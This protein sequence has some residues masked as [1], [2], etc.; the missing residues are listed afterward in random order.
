MRTPRRRPSRPLRKRPRIDDLADEEPESSS[1]STSSESSE[2]SPPD[3]AADADDEEGYISALEEKPTPTPQ[4]RRPSRLAKPRCFLDAVRPY[5]EP[6]SKDAVKLSQLT[7]AEINAGEAYRG[8]LVCTDADRAEVEA[9]RVTAA[10]L[11]GYDS[12]DFVDDTEEVIPQIETRSVSLKRRTRSRNSDH[13]S[14]DSESLSSESSSDRPSEPESD[15][16]PRGSA[17]TIEVRSSHYDDVELEER[18][19]G[20]SDYEPEKNRSPPR[21]LFRLVRSDKL[22]PGRHTS[23]SGGESSYSNLEDITRKATEGSSFTADQSPMSETRGRPGSK[24]RVRS[25]QRRNGP[26]ASSHVIEVVDLSHDRNHDHD[27]QLPG[28]EAMTARSEMTGS[29]NIQETRPSTPPRRVPS[30]V[31]DVVDLCDDNCE[32]GGRKEEVIDLSMS[33]DGPVKVVQPPVEPRRN[34]RTRKPRFRLN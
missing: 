16:S 26:F 11:A 31:L 9:A 13:S 14:S 5:V 33:D 2:D 29:T 21:K 27:T 15:G 34:L 32:E 12:D 23:D 6:L 17:Q 7:M 30:R 25:T 8:P 20:S 19:Q 3:F 18:E 22:T 1:D 10:S 24:S 28:T 4:P